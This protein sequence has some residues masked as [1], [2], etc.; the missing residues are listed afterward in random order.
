MIGRILTRRVRLAM[1]AQALALLVLGFYFHGLYT[2]RSGA[3]LQARQA[4]L[5]TRAALSAANDQEH[6]LSD[7]QTAFSQ[8]ATTEQNY[9][10]RAAGTACADGKLH[11]SIS[12]PSAAGPLTESCK[13]TGVASSVLPSWLSGIL[14][15]SNN[16]MADAITRDLLILAATDSTVHHLSQGLLAA[17]TR[18]ASLAGDVQQEEDRELA[19][20]SSASGALRALALQVGGSVLLLAAAGAGLR[21]AKTGTQVDQVAIPGQGGTPGP[22]WHGWQPIL[23]AKLVSSAVSALGDPAAMER[24]REEWSCDMAEIT[25]KWQQLRWAVLLRIFAP[26]G[27]RAAL[28]HPAAERH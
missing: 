26:P 24:Y 18:I 27:I 14:D 10:T 3:A 17:Q 2:A 1:A 12:V 21:R 22:G 28:R 25:G 8:T 20:N 15:P 16:S 13:V 7:R 11:E 19:G 4:V 9:V 23:T 6:L 5:S